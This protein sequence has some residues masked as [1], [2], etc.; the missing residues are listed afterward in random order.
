MAKS[1]EMK[2]YSNRSPKKGYTWETPPEPIPENQI[3]ETLE[4][5]FIVV[6]GGISG[7]AAAA[8]CSS[9][10]LSGILIDKNRKMVA[11]A[12]Q[13]AAINTKIMAEKGV[14]IDPKRFAADWLKVSGSRVEEEL[15]WIFI[16]RS[17][18]GFEWMMSLTE[19]GVDSNIFVSYKGPMFGEYLGTHHIFNKPG[20]KYTNFGGGMLACEI[21]EKEFLKNG[22]Q[23]YRGTAAEQLEKDADGRVIAA[24]AKGADGKYRRYKG[25]KA[26]IL[27]TGDASDDREMLAAFCP[28]GLRPALQI[29]RRGNKGDGQ[30]MAYW[31]GAVLDNPEWAPTLHAL[32]YSGHQFFF[33]HV[34]QLGNRFMN[35][36]TWM[37]A[38]S[39]RCLM[40][41]GGDFAFTVFDSKYLDEI[42]ERWELLGG[43][44][45]APMS[46]MG[47]EFDRAGLEDDI[48]RFVTGNERRY[49]DIE[50]EENTDAEK[51]PVK[52][53][54]INGFKADTIEELAQQ[55]DVPAENLVKT[56]ARYNELV[57]A[58]DD[59]DFG[60]RAIMLTPLVK[61]PFYALRWGPALLDV[62]GGALINKQLNVVGADSHPIPGLYAVGNAAGG[63][64]A[65][66]YPLLLNGNSYGRALAYAMQLGDVLSD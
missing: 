58:G 10:G 2:F 18:E 49:G 27:A 41:P 63:M 3:E 55:L 48:N 22:G 47:D 64:Y 37:Q 56:V 54:L 34:N 20:S 6:G 33:L 32:G 30:K 35:E 19:G 50:D 12:G 52:E 9:K 38:K 62:F 21:L 46:M 8:R 25:K 51:A 15:L 59:T 66:D 7:L 53:K 57:A 42:A 43:Q 45:M 26:V 60:K 65:V 16:N 36:D 13:I 40:Q 5:D 23:L 31:A 61:P 11:L 24:I 14:H 44:G 17:A 28:I 29:P 39:V 4:A 1:F